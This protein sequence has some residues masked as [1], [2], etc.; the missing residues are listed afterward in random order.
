[1]P[2]HTPTGTVTPG[3]T[4]RG[5]MRLNSATGPGISDVGIHLSLASYGLGPVVATIN[6]NGRCETPFFHI[7]HDEMV[8]AWAEL[9]G[10]TFDPPHEY[11][12]QVEAQDCFDSNS[13]ASLSTDVCTFSHINDVRFSPF[14]HVQTL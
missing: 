5:R 3:L 4:V 2:I 12:A 14:F 11:H 6:V 1:M 13:L 9:S 8:T 7:P 10:Y